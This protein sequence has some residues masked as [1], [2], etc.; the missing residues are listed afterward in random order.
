MRESLVVIC[1]DIADNRRRRHVAEYLEGWGDRVQESVFE[2]HLL[3]AQLKEVRDHI[4]VEIDHDS[5]KIRY[6]SLCGKDR[7]ALRILG[8]GRASRAVAYWMA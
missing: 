2:C 7:A 4:A 1:Y 6:Y 3:P 8:I 5:D